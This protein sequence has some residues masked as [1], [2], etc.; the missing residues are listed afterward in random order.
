MGLSLLAALLAML[1]YACQS[2]APVLE[3]QAW[4]R[5]KA[6]FI[7]TSGRV[8]DTGNGNISHSEGQGYGMLLAEAAGD[9]ET[10]DRLWHWTQ[11]NLQIRE[12]G[13]FAWKWIPNDTNATPDTNNATDGDLLIAWA[14]S[15]A[16]NRWNDKSYLRQAKEIIRTIKQTLVK[17]SP[18][19]PVLLPGAEGFVKQGGQTL[20]L[21]YWIF[22][23]ITQVQRLDPDPLWS[24]VSET[25]RRLINAARFGKAQLPP[26]WLQMN[27]ELTLAEGFAPRFGFDAL[28]IPLYLCWGRHH[29]APVIRAIANFWNSFKDQNPP[30]WVALTDGETAPYN[31][32]A[33]IMNVVA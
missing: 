5:Y 12:D 6:E 14:L 25:G 30:A 4:Q 8:I 33:G 1:T 22:P 17:P 27:D 20:N 18:Y 32:S 24:Q 31:L 13:L 15:R 11:I 21:S 3:L 29:T 28:R 26:D 23:A 7:A 19:G 9:R 16:S 2:P 10:F